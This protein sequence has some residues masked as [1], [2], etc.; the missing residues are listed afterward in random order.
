MEYK[1][2][3]KIA[4]FDLD[5]TLL[6]SA[7]DLIDSLNLLLKEKN[8]SPMKKSNVYRLVGNGALAM[9]REAYKL[10]NNNE[11]DIDWKFLQKR[12]LE[13]YKTQ[14]LNKSTLYPHTEDTLKNLR[15]NKINMIIV[16]NKPSY[17]VKKIL[18]HYK[19]SKYFDAVSGGDT[20]NFRKPDPNH[21]FS[22]IKL[23]GI[24]KYNCCFIGDSKNDALCAEKADVKL[25]LLRHGY[26][27]HNLDKFNASYVLSNLK[28]LSSKICKLLL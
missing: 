19:I 26:S 7:D 17:F 18:E 24:E 1:K 28:N 8:Q 11:K 23:A 14:C 21:L 15:E 16:S 3:F 6:D 12:F 27:L 25:I 10:N 9:I 13:I 5:G 4:A 2:V 22:T 20:F